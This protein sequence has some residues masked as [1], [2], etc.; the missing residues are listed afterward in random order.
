MLQRF[1][2]MYFAIQRIRYS[3]KRYYAT[4][5]VRDSEFVIEGFSRPAN[6]LVSK[7]LNLAMGIIKK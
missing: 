5:V 1:P 3:M 2:E 4:I 6:I 7:L